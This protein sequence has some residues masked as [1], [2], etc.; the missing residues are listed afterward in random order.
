[1]NAVKCP[2]CNFLHN[3]KVTVKYDTTPPE[4]G[5][6]YFNMAKT[7]ENVNGKLM[8][9]T[10]YEIEARCP[11]RGIPF[12]ILVDPK[13]PEGTYPVEFIVEAIFP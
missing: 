4:D 3:Y 8:E 5:K 7:I 10:V 6:P 12:R 11:Y 1:M 13:L 2:L 9:I